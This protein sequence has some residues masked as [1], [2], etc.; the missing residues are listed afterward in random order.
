MAG[1]KIENYEW[2]AA[3]GW[4]RDSDGRSSPYVRLGLLQRL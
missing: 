3:D 1:L 4:A 2:S